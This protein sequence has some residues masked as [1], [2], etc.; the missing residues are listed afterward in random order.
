ML[1]TSTKP[2]EKTAFERALV[3]RFSQ[4]T[5]FE[6][7]YTEAA[8]SPETAIMTRTFPI[9]CAFVSDCLDRSCLGKLKENGVGL[10]VLRS[11]GFN[12]VDLSAARELGIQVMRVPRYSPYAVAEF[13]VGLYLSLNRKIHRSHDR[14]KEGNFSLN[15]LVGRDVHNQTVGIVG[16]GNI[17]RCAARIFRGFDAKV[18]A[19]DIQPNEDWARQNGVQYTDL[20]SL[21]ENSDVVSLHAPLNK[22]TFHLLNE[23]TISSMKKNSYLINTSRGALVDTAALIQALKSKHLAGAALDVYEEEEHYFFKDFSDVIIDDDTLARL[24]TFPN[25]LITS[26]QAFLTEEALDE[27]ARVTLQN[28]IDWSEKKLSSN[29]L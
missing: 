7:T 15:G 25:V 24:M 9:V 26:H 8:L 14:V 16:T 21:L 1:M 5:P 3:N 13:A 17:G 11:A 10:L 12:H 19:F 28:M 23:K 4:N 6:V 2:F 20:S 18:L 22:E 29:T 27:I